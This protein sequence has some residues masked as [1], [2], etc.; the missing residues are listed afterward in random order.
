MGD[1]KPRRSSDRNR[2]CK[3]QDAWASRPHSISSYATTFY[4]RFHLSL[5]HRPSYSFF[6][7]LCFGR[8]HT[9]FWVGNNFFLE[10]GRRP[11]ACCCR[12][13]T[14]TYPFQLCNFPHDTFYYQF[15]IKT[16]SVS[17]S[18]RPASRTTFPV[19]LVTTVRVHFLLVHSQEVDLG[20]VE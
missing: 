3:R 11:P 12:N 18:S 17:I 5:L 9:R 7:S 14:H 6:I 19:L 1:Q 20:L 16:S 8:N 15:K 13:S 10:T 4:S 2:G